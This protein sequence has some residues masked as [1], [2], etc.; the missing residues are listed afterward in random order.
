MRENLIK[1]I[2][3]QFIAFFPTSLVHQMCFFFLQ[4]S[5]LFHRIK[6]L[7]FTKWGATQLQSLNWCQRNKYVVRKLST[8]KPIH[9]YFVIAF[10]TSS[11]WLVVVVGYPTPSEGWGHGGRPWSPRNR[12]IPQGLDQ[13]SYRDRESPKSER[14]KDSV[15]GQCRMR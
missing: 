11:F 5:A 9:G 14:R 12:A 1:V 10:V 15:A 4:K 2:V 6:I 13:R 8:V 7:P 3:K